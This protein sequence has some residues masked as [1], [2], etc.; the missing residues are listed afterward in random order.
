MKSLAPED[1]GAEEI[2][3]IRRIQGKERGRNAPTAE[4]GEKMMASWNMR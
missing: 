1:R 2:V 4:R 3:G